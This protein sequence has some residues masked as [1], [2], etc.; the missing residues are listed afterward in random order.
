M[1]LVQNSGSTIPAVV[2]AVRIRSPNSR[3]GAAVY[4]D[5][6]YVSHSLTTEAASLSRAARTTA[7]VLLVT[8]L[9][10]YWFGLDTPLTVST[11]RSV[12]RA[13]GNGLVCAH[14]TV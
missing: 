12:S 1:K 4:S 14:V 3:F 8:R 6:V 5:T 7:A 11:P 10:R 2:D 9:V 13:N